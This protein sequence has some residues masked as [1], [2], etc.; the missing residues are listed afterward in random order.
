MPE[1]TARL[2]NLPNTI[3]RAQK[4][5]ETLL[6]ANGGNFTVIFVLLYL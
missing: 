1:S 2:N 3:E 4:I 6:A 5:G